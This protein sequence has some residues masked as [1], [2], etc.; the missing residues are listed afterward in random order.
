MKN[1]NCYKSETHGLPQF[2]KIRNDGRLLME[3]VRGSTAYGTNIEGISDVDT[4]G[5]YICTINELLGYNSYYK[6][7]SDSKSDNK[8]Y[9]LGNFINLLVKANPNILEALFVP[10]NC[11]IGEVHPIMQYLRE[12]RE[13]FLTKKCFATIFGYATSQIV[14]ARGLNKK[15]VNPITERKTPLDFTYTFLNQGSQPILNWLNKYGLKPEYCGLNKI[16]HM[17]DMYGLYYDWKHNLADEPQDKNKLEK[18][19]AKLDPTRVERIGD[20]ENEV[21]KHYRGL[22]TEEIAHTTQLRLSSIDDKYDKPLCHISYNVDGFSDH[23]RKYKEYQEWVKKRNPARYESN[24]NKNYDCYLNSETE[25]LTINGWKKYDDILDDELIASFDNNHNIQFVPI[26]NRFSDSY[27]GTIYTFENRYIRF[28]VTDNH[29]MYVSPIHRNISTNFSTKYIKEKS[30]WQLIK[31][32]DLFD[33]T[34]SY[35]HQLRHLNNNN[36]DYNI[37][38]DELIILGAFLSEGTFE[39]NKNHE[40]NAI[41]IG[42]YEHKDF[43]NIIRNIKSINIK[44]YKSIRNE[45]NDIEISWIIRDSNILN[46]C[47]QCNGYYSYEKELPSFCNKLSKRQV[48]ILLHIMILGDGT[49]NKNNGHYVYYTSSKKLADS[50][51][52]LLLCNGYNCQFYGCND[53]Y[54]H[55]NGYKRKDNIILPKYQIF[56]SKNTELTN[57]IHFNENDKH[58]SIRNVNNERIVCFENKNHTLV[59]RN[60]YKVAFHG[61]SKNMMHCFRLIHMGKEIA[62]GK[63]MIIERTWDHDFLMNIRN[64]KYEYDYLITLLDKE[65]EEMD[66]LM[67]QSNLPDEIDKTKLNELLF[68]LRIEQIKEQI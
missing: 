8:W 18:I 28:S 14:K 44:E 1:Y 9:E 42:Q 50:L 27:S 32:K 52:T 53:N 15:I 13:M 55:K 20:I 51:Y 33:D 43:T 37:T 65:K 35:F 7:V 2:D 56:I 46:I 57:M 29:K 36:K 31:I 61:N 22:T 64:H 60:N 10:D 23:C 49:K 45:K 38:D 24:L 16:P 34:R 12:N 68:K 62:Q 39:Y 54:L 30:N 47:K 21:I 6:E 66:E 5:V 41:C 58:W 17:D 19:R 67:K 11:I 25:F 3:Y 4:G 48:D 63:S 40:I 26:L 59:T